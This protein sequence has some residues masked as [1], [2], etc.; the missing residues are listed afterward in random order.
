MG[1]KNLNR[2][3]K[4]NC[5]NS[6]QCINISDL[7]G[8][9]IVVDISIY[10]YKYEA[11]DALMENMYLMLSIFRYSNITPIFI[12]DGKSPPEKA[13]LLQKRR[14]T[15]IESKEEYEKLKIQLKDKEDKDDI[16]DIV[17]QMSQLKRQF[18]FMN[19]E[20]IQNVKSLIIAYGATYFDAPG[21]ADELCALLVIKKKVWACLSEDMDMFVYGCTRVL[22]YFSLVNNTVVLYYMKGILK[23]LNITQKE[24][25]EICILSGTDYNI[26]ANGKE[27]KVDLMQTLKYFW[28]Y[29][30]YKK[31]NFY[32]WLI[33][34]TDYIVDNELLIKINSIFDLSNKNDKLA[35]FNKIKIIDGPKRDDQIRKIMQEYDFIF[36]NP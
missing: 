30:K 15:R 24:F 25:K 18:T 4:D 12:F 16:K 26:S 27:T 13:N 2:Y 17:S 9:K 7:N 33:E 20:K 21:E 23:D 3:L 19:Q 8:K 10:L 6:I 32:D 28:K 31:D 35:I 29:K 22:R 36:L 14:E 5:N 11:D 1:I 34:N